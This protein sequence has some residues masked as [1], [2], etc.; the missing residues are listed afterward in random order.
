MRKYIEQMAA[1]AKIFSVLE[2]QSAFWQIRLD[3]AKLCTFNTP[4][5]RY[6]FTRLPFGI[7]SAPEVFQRAV[8]Q[9]LENV[10]KV[11][12][13]WMTSSCGVKM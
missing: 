11:D 2:A 6:R 8:S 13:I 10:P 9:M 1:G 7:K 3:E 4:F 5:G 12:V